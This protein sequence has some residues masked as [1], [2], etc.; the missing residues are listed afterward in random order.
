[1][2]PSSRRRRR[3]IARVPGQTGNVRVEGSRYTINREPDS[4][5]VHKGQGAGNIRVEGDSHNIH[6]HNIMPRTGKPRKPKAPLFDFQ[7][8]QD[9]LIKEVDFYINRDGIRGPSIKEARDKL[10]KQSRWPGIIHG[11]NP[12]RLADQKYKKNWLPMHWITAVEALTTTKKGIIQFNRDK[13][14]LAKAKKTR[15]GVEVEERVAKAEQE[16]RVKAIAAIEE[17][18]RAVEAKEV[19]QHNRSFY[20]KKFKDAIAK[21]RMEFQL[22]MDRITEE[23]NRGNKFSGTK[24]GIDRESKRKKNK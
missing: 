10:K 15:T 18:K 11:S 9:A 20:E 23:V 16:Y 19:E 2:P 3:T 12:R 22:E 17:L 21:A 14:M 24:Y 8:M 5:E 13:R 7:L 1:M 6:I 4:F